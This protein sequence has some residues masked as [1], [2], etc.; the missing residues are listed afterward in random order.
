MQLASKRTS[1]RL[2]RTFV[3]ASASHQTPASSI[4]PSPES[5]PSADSGPGPPSKV[6]SGPGLSHFLEDNHGRFH[7]YL[8]ISVSERCNLR[9]SYCMPEAGVDLTPNSKLLTT[10]EMVKLAK[11][12][13]THGVDKIRLTGG[14]PLVRKDIVHLVKQLKDIDGI[15]TVAMTTNGLTLGRHLPPLLEAGLDAVNISLVMTRNSSLSLE[16]QWLVIQRYY[17]QLTLRWRVD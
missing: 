17:V 3:T 8:R 2:L 6:L 1:L 12:F 13:A 7:N 14:E 10:E 4:E 16:G 9:C 11:V 15:S 5:K